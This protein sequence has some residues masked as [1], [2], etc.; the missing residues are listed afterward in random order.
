MVEFKVQ[1][2]ESLVQTFGYNEVE[3]QLQAF[4]HKMMLKLA[5]QDILSDLHTFDLENDKEW[6]TARNLAWKQEKHKYYP[7]FVLDVRS[8]NIF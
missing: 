4:M 8:H 5:A 1:L 2:E 3:R 6:Q 7:N